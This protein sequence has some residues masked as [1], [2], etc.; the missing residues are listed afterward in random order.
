VSKKTLK[1]SKKTRKRY[2]MQELIYGELERLSQ[3]VNVEE[4]EYCKQRKKFL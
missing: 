3:V 2:M 1:D 4:E